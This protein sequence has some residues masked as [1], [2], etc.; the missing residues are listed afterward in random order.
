MSTLGGGPPPAAA[1]KQPALA[2]GSNATATKKNKKK[3]KK[4]KKPSSASPAA[5]SSS[6]PTTSNDTYVYEPSYEK[7]LAWC[8]KQLEAGLK[9]PAITPEQAAESNSVLKKLQNPKGTMP[10]KRHLMKVVFGNY[11]KHIE[12]EERKEWQRKRDQQVAAQHKLQLEQQEEQ[13]P[14][15]ASTSTSTT[16]TTEEEEDEEQ[17]QQNEGEEGTA[18]QECFYHSSLVTPLRVV[19]SFNFVSQGMFVFLIFGSSARLYLVWWNVMTLQT[20]PLGTTHS[21]L[22][23]TDTRT[24][25]RGITRVQGKQLSTEGGYKDSLDIDSHSGSDE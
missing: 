21:S 10:N 16:T 1:A 11:R 15:D 9:H 20:A 5:T 25:S 18:S 3:N 17:E 22:T 8:I 12:E 14:R 23:G 6:T 7:E 13:P 19:A 24:T 2:A 4:K